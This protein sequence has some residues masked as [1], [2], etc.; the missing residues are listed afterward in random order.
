MTSRLLR[1]CTKPM[2]TCF[3]CFRTLPLDDFYRH[4]KMSDGH[5][6]K[7]K[8]CT[9]TDS[10]RHR[11]EN[12]EQERARDRERP[13]RISQSRVPPMRRKAQTAVGNAVRDGRLDRPD[14]CSRCGSD[15]SRIEG[16][17]NDYSKP[18]DVVW[19]CVPCHRVVHGQT[20]GAPA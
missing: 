9:K 1:V 19:L 12:I 3:K 17:H 20:M 18:L 5:L 8:D 13:Y 7:C 6:N 14:S 10:R 16:H 11:W 2:K 15:G 4:S